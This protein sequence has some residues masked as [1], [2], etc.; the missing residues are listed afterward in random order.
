MLKI[1]TLNCI[2][3]AELDDWEKDMRIDLCL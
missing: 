3:F 2:T 1:Y